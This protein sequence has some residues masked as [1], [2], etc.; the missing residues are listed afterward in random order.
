MSVKGDAQ[1][2][3]QYLQLQFV[4]FLEMICRMALK[5]HESQVLNG[6]QQQMKLHDVVYK[7]IDGLFQSHGVFPLLK[8][9]VLEGEKPPAADAGGAEK[10]RSQAAL[11]SFLKKHA[12]AAALPSELQAGEGEVVEP[13]THTMPPDHE[14]DEDA[15]LVRAY[16]KQ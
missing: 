9:E 15:D 12:G 11:D 6:T 1:S 4:E 3:V 14:I 16:I 7:Y 2:Q 8:K 10:R 5:E 13:Q